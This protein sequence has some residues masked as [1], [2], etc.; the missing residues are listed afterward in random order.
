MFWLR[1]KKIDFFKN[2]LLSR[3]LFPSNKIFVRIFNFLIFSSLSYF[4]FFFYKQIKAY[5]LPSSFV[6][7]MSSV[8]KNPVFGPMSI[9]QSQIHLF[10]V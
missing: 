6:L 10:P 7:E 4:F 8:T 3:E 9:S 1:N 2:A 5:L